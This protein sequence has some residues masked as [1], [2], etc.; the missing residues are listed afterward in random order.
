MYLAAIFA[1][2]FLYLLLAASIGLVGMFAWGLWSS[3]RNTERARNVLAE[4][5]CPNCQV[6]FG[7]DAVASA[8]AAWMEY[9]AQF[10]DRNSLIRFRLVR[11]WFIACARCG[12]KG[13]FSP[14]TCRL[15]PSEEEHNKPP[16][17]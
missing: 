2:V 8:E 14:D 1:K 17:K 3:R 15:T 7:V 11:I 16:Q 4:M 13:N 12:W 9:L 6:P 10:R 5:N